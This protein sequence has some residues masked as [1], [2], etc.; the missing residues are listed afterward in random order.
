MVKYKPPVVSYVILSK[1]RRI[2]GGSMQTYVCSINDKRLP[3]GYMADTWRTVNGERVKTQTTVFIKPG[4]PETMEVREGFDWHW[5]AGKNGIR[6][7]APEA[8]AA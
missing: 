2:A 6:Y 7:K 4:K 5:L 3:Y 1:K 8:K